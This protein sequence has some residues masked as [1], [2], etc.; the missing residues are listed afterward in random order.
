[1]SDLLSAEWKFT[2]WCQRSQMLC[3]LKLAVCQSSNVEPPAFPERPFRAGWLADLLSSVRVQSMSLSNQSHIDSGTSHD[4]TVLA[5]IVC[6]LFVDTQMP[7]VCCV[8][9]MCVW[10]LLS[11]WSTMATCVQ[12]VGAWLEAWALWL[13]VDSRLSQHLTEF[14]VST[15]QTKP[16]LTESGWGS[17][18]K[19][20]CCNI[21]EQYTSFVHLIHK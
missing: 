4:V 17:D 1:M 12:W 3:C 8:E 11:I 6:S 21:L 13:C 7:S 16:I 18:R 19:Y 5:L 2:Q 20:L 9:W 10:L 14:K 15:L